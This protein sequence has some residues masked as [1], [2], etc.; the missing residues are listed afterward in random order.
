[1][2]SFVLQNSTYEMRSIG[3]SASSALAPPVRV[4]PGML[5]PLQLGESRRA[6]GVRGVNRGVHHS[7]KGLLHSLEARRALCK[8]ANG[9]RDPLPRFVFDSRQQPLGFLDRSL[10]ISFGEH[11]DDNLL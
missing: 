7:K 11:T 10:D 1:V 8:L 5:A 4:L 6:R 9:L 2:A 3:A